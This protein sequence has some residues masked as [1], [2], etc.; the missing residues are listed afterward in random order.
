MSTMF[1]IQNF[2]RKAQKIPNVP[3]GDVSETGAETGKC[4]KQR[5]IGI[6]QS[7]MLSVFPVE[8]YMLR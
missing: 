4:F 8:T 1:H 2:R 5:S 6:A 3:K 7:W